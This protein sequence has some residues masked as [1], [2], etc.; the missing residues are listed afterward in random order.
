V[1]HPYTR[2]KHICL[3]IDNGSSHASGD[4][5]AFF[6]NLAPRVRVLFT[7]VNPSWLNQAE[8]LIEAFTDRY[9]YRGNWSSQTMML[10]PL[11]ASRV[12]YNRSFA[13]PF[14]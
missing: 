10:N 1:L 4:T 2:A 3:I 6:R 14:D 7:P 9:L 12:E 8:S 11:I 5:L 13:R